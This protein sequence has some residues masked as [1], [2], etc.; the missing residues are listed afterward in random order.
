M[1]I[2]YHS[3]LSVAATC[4]A[5]FSTCPQLTGRDGEPGEPSNP[6]LVTPGSMT[7]KNLKART[8]L[9]GA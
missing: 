7:P 3:S 1:A 4:S 2:T 5:L 9:P 8:A 6:S